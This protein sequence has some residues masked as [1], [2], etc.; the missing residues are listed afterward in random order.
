VAPAGAPAHRR[1]CV[2]CARQS[3][4]LVHVRVYIHIDIHIPANSSRLDTRR[5]GL[6]LSPHSRPVWRLSP[7]GAGGRG[8]SNRGSDRNRPSGAAERGGRRRE[9]RSGEHGR[10]RRNRKA[11]SEKKTRRQPR[12]NTELC[13]RTQCV[14][15]CQDHSTP[16]LSG[17]RASRGDRGYRM[18]RLL[19]ASELLWVGV[20]SEPLALRSVG[21]GVSALQRCVT[22]CSRAQRCPAHMLKDMDPITGQMQSSQRHSRLARRLQYAEARRVSSRNGL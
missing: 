12:T 3:P 11:C 16:C 13:I 17:A 20:A 8:H 21:D 5:H 15:R 22:G 18:S 4:P 7:G 10:G 14:S 1:P 2:N 19:L 6:W 9:G